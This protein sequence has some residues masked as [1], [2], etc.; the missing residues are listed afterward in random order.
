M[1]VTTQATTTTQTQIT[2]NLHL[3]IQ[4]KRN[5]SYYQKKLDI[6]NGYNADVIWKAESVRFEQDSSCVFKRFCQ[7]CTRFEDLHLFDGQKRACKAS[8]EKLASK[9][10]GNYKKDDDDDDEKDGG[11]GSLL[12]TTI[13]NINNDDVVPKKDDSY[14]DDSRQ[15]TIMVS[16]DEDDDEKKRDII[17]IAEQLVSIIALDEMRKKKE[18]KIGSSRSSSSPEKKRFDVD[19]ARER[20]Q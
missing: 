5:R 14:K 17:D 16:S 3:K 18:E 10:R 15:R 7:K 19:S 20:E 6:I 9:R 1:I 11:G 4:K 12:L 13:A 2:N 8:L